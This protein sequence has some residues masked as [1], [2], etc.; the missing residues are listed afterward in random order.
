MIHFFHMSTLHFQRSLIESY[1]RTC[2]W[3]VNAND[4]HYRQCYDV[5]LHCSN[6]S[7]AD[8]WGW[9][10]S[11]KRLFSGPVLEMILKSCNMNTTTCADLRRRSATFSKGEG[12]FVSSTFFRKKYR[13]VSEDAFWNFLPLWPKRNMNKTVPMYVELKMGYNSPIFDEYQYQTQSA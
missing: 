10:E 8:D 4:C 5:R 12:L 7:F 2:S 6:Q 1:P 3:N 11:F 9:C 13:L